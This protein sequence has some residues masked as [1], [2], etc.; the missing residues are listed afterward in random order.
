M[1][2]LAC[3]SLFF[4]APAVAWGQVVSGLWSTA[5]DSDTLEVTEYWALDL[6]QDGTY[7][8][9]R[10][11]NATDP[12]RLE[13]G[14][15]QLHGKDLVL[16]TTEGLPIGPS[17][18]VLNAAGDSLLSTTAAILDMVRAGQSAWQ[19][20]T[21]TWEF[22]D[23]SGAVTAYITFGPDRYESDVGG[24][25]SGPYRRIGASLVLWADEATDPSLMGATG[26]WFDVVITDGA[27]EYSIN[28]RIRARAVRRV[29]TVV[30]PIGWAHVKT[31]QLA[32]RR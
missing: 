19:D 23:A 29:A 16:S 12:Y 30:Q 32:R 5:L 14:R 20:L 13:A 10:L 3:L 25:Q 21:G 15:Y 24:Y 9:Y 4:L 1:T 31:D 28:S 7:E 22:V 18:F 2:R 6:R 27:L 11:R 17:D 8:R 26:L